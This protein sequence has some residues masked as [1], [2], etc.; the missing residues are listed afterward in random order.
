MLEQVS[1]LGGGLAMEGFVIQKKDFDLKK[2]WDRKPEEVLEDRGD[3]V[4]RVGE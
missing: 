2:L 3:A 4:R 1:E